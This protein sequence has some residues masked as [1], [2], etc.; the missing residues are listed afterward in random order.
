MTAYSADKEYQLRQIH[1]S[2]NHDADG[3]PLRE[4]LVRYHE[5][6]D[7][8]MSSVRDELD[9]LKDDERI[10]RV[11]QIKHEQADAAKRS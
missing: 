5:W 2:L 11:G 3:R 6:L 1:D 4:V 7:T 8:L 9:D 10:A